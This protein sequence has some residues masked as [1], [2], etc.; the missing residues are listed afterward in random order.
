MP[1]RIAC[2]RVGS[3][4]VRVGAV[5][6]HLRRVGFLFL[7]GVAF[8]CGSN[9]AGQGSFDLVDGTGPEEVGL[10]DVPADHGPDL[11]ATPDV[12]DGTAQ[13]HDSFPDGFF[14]D[15]DAG[16]FG[17][18]GKPCAGNDDCESGVCIEVD[19][20]T[21]VCTINCVE[22]CPKDW[23]CKGIA[24]GGPDL[25]FVCVPPKANLCK[26][27]GGNDDCLYQGDLCVPVGASGNFCL[28]DC[29]G[30]Q[31]CPLHYTCT[32]MEI[33]GLDEPV[34]L[35]TPDTGSCICTHELDQTTEECSAS[36]EFGKCFG[37]KLC[38]GD[39]GW[40]ECD[41]AT[42]QAETCNGKDDDC[43]GTADE[44]LADLPCVKKN[45]HGECKGMQLCLG[46]EGLQCDAQEPGPE[47]CDGEDNNC[48]NQVD[49]GFDDTDSDG[50]S[51]CI[52]LDD[53]GDGI[54]DTVDNC[55][56][57]ANLGQADHDEDGLGDA[58][59]E[60]DDNDGVPD[61]SDNCP[62]VANP[63]QGDIDGDKL[64]DECDDDMDGDGS[65][66]PWDCNPTD[67]AIYPNAAE[68]CDGLDNNCNL[69]SDEG[70]PDSDGDALADCA[71]LDDDNDG[72]PDVTDCKP[73]DPEVGNGLPEVCDGKDN[74]CTG[75]VDEGFPDS[76]KDGIADCVDIDSD[77]D[78]IP[79]FQDN[80]PLVPN[81]DQV[82]TDGDPMGDACDPDDDNDGILDDGDGSGVEGDKRCTGGLTKGC[83]DNCRT[84]INQLQEDLDQDLLGNACDPDADGD[85]FVNEQD[86]GPFDSTIYPGA[87]EAC[88]SF[89][90]NCN[91]PIDEGFPDVDKDGVANC[92]D[93]DDDNDLDPDLTDCAPFDPA[94]HHGAQEI[95]DGKDNDCNGIPDDGCPPAKLRFHQLEARIIGVAGD[96]KAE[97]FFG[98]PA[99]R[100]LVGTEAGFKIRFGYVH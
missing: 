91:G 71:D 65:P 63:G 82:N 81:V 41:A 13:D 56:L 27:C 67:P 85:G 2:R 1:R 77:G 26:T 55:D 9:P 96:V 6:S 49:E 66:N 14:A 83:D 50:A 29:S 34:S 86:C 21:S 40:T 73:L 70:Y 39:K 69:F 60:D 8:A 15:S 16:P 31:G 23:V 51:D 11:P 44:E 94:F 30:G 74:N 64:G 42:P 24:T 100:E 75:I 43:D 97:L 92:V 80:C 12:P 32:V 47:L 5:M 20:D 88:N 53:D 90:D 89:D 36:N 61:V 33:A 3:N 38:D 62:F 98:R 72:D 22:E 87:P 59:D 4:E 52:D 76:D 78:G 68:V 93:P 17:D 35:C 7:C 58:C 48:D 84:I 45:E 79:N 19:E 95:C 99:I 37:E 10:A 54:L 28:T 57:I 46:Q 18:W 25:T